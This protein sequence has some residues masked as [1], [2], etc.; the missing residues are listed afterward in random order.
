MIYGLA[1]RL[2]LPIS[3]ILN[4]PVDEFLTWLAFIKIQNEKASHG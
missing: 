1:D 3:E 4:M 2:Q